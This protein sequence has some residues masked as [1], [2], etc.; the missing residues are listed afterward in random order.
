MT[1]ATIIPD[2][3]IELDGYELAPESPGPLASL[4][5][6][7]ILGTPDLCELTFEELPGG[8]PLGTSLFGKSMKVTLDG[9]SDPLFV[10][11][12]TG[13]EHGYG[14]NNLRETRI[15]GYDLLHR[16][17]KSQPVRVHTDATAKS[18]AEELGAT[19]GVAVEASYDG[20]AWPVL[21]QYRQ[22][23]LEFLV[24][25]AQRCG[26]YPMLQ[27]TDLKLIT[28][29]G[30][31]DS[32]PLVLG[33]ALL[34]V[35][36]DV[37][38]APG[39]GEVAASGWDTSLV[40]LREGSA[41]GSSAGSDIEAGRVPLPSSTDASRT[42]VDEA[43]ASEDHAEFL[44]QA[45]LDRRAAEE[46][47]L[48]AVAEGDPRLRPGIRVE[49]KGVLDDLVGSYVLTSVGHRIDRDVGFVSELSTEVPPSRVRPRSAITSIGVVSAIDDPEE[50]GRLRVRLPAYGDVET[51]WIP[52]LSPGAG[53]GKGL[54]TLPDVDDHVLCIFGNEDPARAFVLGG[55]YGA[56]GPPD[57]GIEEGSVRRY[58]LLTPGNHRVLL[59]DDKQLVRIE[60]TTGS[61]V[62]MSPEGVRLHAAVDMQIDAPGKAIIVRS[63][64]VD[65]V[66]AP[67]VEE[68]EA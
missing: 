11:E 3:T 27:G 18:I 4:E 30:D 63:K 46:V 36:I 6:R 5:V 53:E 9:F 32:D 20:P 10:G 8:Q 14:A 56:G 23:D 51:G 58:T 15:R 16:L 45:E 55:L 54:M 21:I 2:I 13:V 44:A 48:R 39:C 49:V 50:I 68:T 61:F 47:V 1:H 62:E 57:S 60:D 28:L 24:D 26:L 40:E 29:E 17:K 34:E 33:E 64:T 43:T 25:V 12:V 35:R 67:E 66:R 41:S 38:G 52:A 37:S 31:G 59:D 65:F 42:L 22:S 7:R 19:L